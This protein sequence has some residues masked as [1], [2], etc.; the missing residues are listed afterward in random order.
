MPFQP[1]AHDRH[2]LLGASSAAT[3]TPS[4]SSSSLDVDRSALY[5]PQWSKRG[6]VIPT[7]LTRAHVE[8]ALAQSEDHGVTLVFLKKN[9][10]DIEASAAEELATTGAK[11]GDAG[12]RVE[13]YVKC[14]QYHF[15]WN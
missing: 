15:K 2:D 5:S 11:S 13:R 6:S 12:G 4:K 8:D 1:A 7:P 9:I 14:R 3:M 10:T